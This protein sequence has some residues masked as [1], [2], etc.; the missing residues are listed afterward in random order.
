M[1]I[2]TWH[3]IVLWIGE[4][5]LI[6]TYAFKEKK[7][8]WIIAPDVLHVTKLILNTVHIFLDIDGKINLKDFEDLIIE[9][10]Y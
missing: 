8:D 1:Y 5:L 10:V 2:L 9:K 6:D 4:K 7:N 3:V